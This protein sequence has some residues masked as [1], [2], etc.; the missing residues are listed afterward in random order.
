MILGGDFLLTFQE[1]VEGDVFDPIRSRIREGR[2]SI[3]QRGAD[4]L[5]Y[6]LLDTVVDHY[7]LVMEKLSDSL[8]DVE[9]VVLDAPGE[10]EVVG[11]LHRLRRENIIL[12]K[13]VWP[14]REMLAVL[15]RG[16]SPLVHEDTVPYLRDVQDHA[17]EVVETVETLRDMTQ[18]L[19]DVHLSMVS[20]R[21]N[22][23][24]KLLTIISTIFVPLT[25][26]V[27]IYGMNF[28]SMP[29]LESAWG[30]PAVWAVMLAVGAGLLVFFRRR[31]WL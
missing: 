6:A 17:M 1:G 8:S 25:F 28:R 7:F 11:V 12:R 24:M 22:E 27:G 31:R 9:E 26:I 15:M 18:S 13:A 30:Y 16:E 10:P 29:E 2:G 20:N 23:V 21:M 14:L 3:R 5:M 4:Y 19:V